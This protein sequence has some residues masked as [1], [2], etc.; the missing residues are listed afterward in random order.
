LNAASP[1]TRSIRSRLVLLVIACIVP[2]ALLVSALIAYTYAQARD[3]VAR[4]SLATARALMVAVDHDLEEIEAELLSLATSAD[5]GRGTI[6]G[7]DALRVQASNIARAHRLAAIVLVDKDL[8]ERMTTLSSPAGLPGS[9]AE[10][11][12]RRVFDTGETLIGDLWV[13]GVTGAPV[14]AVAIPVFRGDEIAYVLCAYIAALRL[15]DML[16]GHRLPA[17]WVGAILDSTGTIVARTHDPQRFVGRKGSP[18]LL[19]R[20]RAVPSGATEGTTL[21]GIPVLSVFSTSAESRWTVALGIPLA[22]LEAP[23]RRSLAWLI[24]GTAALLA[25]SVFLAWSLA[26]RIA[27]SIQRLVEPARMLGRGERVHV[28]ELDIREAHDVALA[29]AE[30]SAMLADARH[31]ANHDAL[32]T[33]ANRALFADLLTHELAVCERTHSPLVVA[34]IDLD[35]FKSINDVHG[36]AV[37]DEVLRLVANRIVHAIRE[38]DVAARLGGDEF[39]VIL[40]NVGFS[41][42]TPVCEKLLE[43]LSVPY[44]V[45]GL[46]LVL[47]ASIGVGAFPDSATTAEALLRR[48]DEALYE[49]K[50]AGKQRYAVARRAVRST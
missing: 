30:A 37:G 44:R 16:I 49:A 15:S 14:V 13:R 43:T 10:P 27:M 8:R 31:R 29:L 26:D 21:E 33:L 48:A 41:S 34:L 35:G 6:D 1:R 28:P 20:M 17:D 38:S 23:L 45:D 36:H 3:E 32:T 4:D 9:A 25:A 46:A 18:S 12:I 11:S 5:I 47:S 22:G 2:G 50:R 39:A 24:A 7:I 40:P 42:A 19:A